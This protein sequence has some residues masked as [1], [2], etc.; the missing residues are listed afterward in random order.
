MKVIFKIFLI[1]F[2]FSLFLAMLRGGY[3][4]VFSVSGHY[5]SS[6]IGFILLSLWSIFCIHKYKKCLKPRYIILIIFLGV[7]FVELYIRSKDFWA[8]YITLP[9]LIIWWL[10]ILS[11]YLLTIISHKSIK[12]GYIIFALALG[13]WL[14]IPGYEFFV[15]HYNFGTFNGFVNERVTYPIRLYNIK[16]GEEN[17]S[18]SD[19]TYIILDF[20][21]SHCGAC[22]EDFPKVQ[23]LYDEIKTIPEVSLY[24][25]HCYMPD[26]GEGLATGQSILEK[27]KY[28]FPSLSLKITDELLDS[29]GVKRY[30][31]VLILDSF[32]NIIYR[33]DIKY[34]KLKLREVIN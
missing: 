31:T 30:P 2:L 32:N 20:W 27:E 11:G 19:H 9:N 33:G 8:T 22:F 10:G 17:F 12:I 29:L 1:S 16:G 13:Y 26:Q 18:S 4:T 28:T 7:S 3:I 5:L 25:V 15:H 6:I 21:Y 34:V 24:S 23:D 14:S